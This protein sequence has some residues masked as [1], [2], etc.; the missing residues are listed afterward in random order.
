MGNGCSLAFLIDPIHKMAMILR[1]G[2]DVVVVND[3]KKSLNG[4][5]VLPG[6]FNASFLV[7]IA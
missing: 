2:Q 6:P 1:L 5:D 4:Y 3:F 7:I